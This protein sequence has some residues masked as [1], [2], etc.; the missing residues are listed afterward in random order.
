MFMKELATASQYR[1]GVVYVVLN[2]FSLGWIKYHQRNLGNRFVATDFKVQPDFVKVAEAS[3]CFGKKVE[4]PEE[5]R[6]ALQRAL[7][8][9]QK[10]MPAVVEFRVDGWDFTPGFRNFYKRLS[11]KI[12]TGKKGR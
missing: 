10:G 4:K 1:A 3:Q 8:A 12:R 2:N 11:G 7:R 5:I 9:A 6:P